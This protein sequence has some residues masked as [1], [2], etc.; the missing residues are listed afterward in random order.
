MLVSIYF[1]IILFT[2]HTGWLGSWVVSMLDSSARRAW[3]QITAATQ[4][5]NSLKQTVHTHRASVFTK[6]Q[7]W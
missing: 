2:M 6:Q 4:S 3:V 7:N 1:T 5:G